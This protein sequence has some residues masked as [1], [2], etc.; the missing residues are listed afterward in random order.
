ME[1]IIGGIPFADSSYAP[2]CPASNAFDGS[3]GTFWSTAKLGQTANNVAFIGLKNLDRQY[4]VSSIRLLVMAGIQTPENVQ[5]KY[6]DDGVMFRDG[7][8]MN[9]P[10]ISEW[11]ELNVPDHIESGTSVTLWCVKAR[12]GSATIGFTVYEIEFLGVGKRSSP[13]STAVL[14]STLPASLTRGFR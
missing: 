9:L 10:A 12:A 14:M 7:P 6:S 11:V 5:L 1:K 2:Q 3:G 8:T 4:K 13:L